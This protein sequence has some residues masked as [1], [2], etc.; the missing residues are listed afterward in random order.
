MPILSSVGAEKSVGVYH[1]MFL[2]VLAVT[3]S[4]YFRRRLS[5]SIHLCHTLFPFLHAGE[6]GP[7]QR[8]Q[9]RVDAP[10]GVR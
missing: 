7:R 3:D 1:C 8:Q 10:A 4:A 5:T 6:H 9:E 2:L